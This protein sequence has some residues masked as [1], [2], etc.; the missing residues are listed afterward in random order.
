MLLL[1][2][3]TQGDCATPTLARAMMPGCARSNCDLMLWVNVGCG[4]YSTDCVCCASTTTCCLGVLCATPL[5]HVE[6]ACVFWFSKSQPTQPTNP[7]KHG[8]KATKPKFAARTMNWMWL[9]DCYYQHVNQ[10]RPFTPVVAGLCIVHHT[11][12]PDLSLSPDLA[13]LERVQP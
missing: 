8:Q 4:D 9:E 6:C 1:A 11:Q 2:P 10:K 5:A 12:H 3:Q 7:K 13:R